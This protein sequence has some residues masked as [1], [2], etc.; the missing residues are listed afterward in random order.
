M[1]G[2][3]LYEV[4]RPQEAEVPQTAYFRIMGFI[5][6]EGADFVVPQEYPL[7]IVVRNVGNIAGEVSTHIVVPELN[8]DAVFPSLLLEAE[9]TT[10]INGTLS[11]PFDFPGTTI[12]VIVTV[13][14]TSTGV[15]TDSTFV[16]IEKAVLGP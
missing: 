3:G 10:T 1:A 16:T 11:I 7:D 5:H 9:T 4:F 14:E 12:T 13:F 8:V 6:P 15:I 2:W